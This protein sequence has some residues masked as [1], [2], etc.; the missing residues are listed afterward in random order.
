MLHGGIVYSLGVAAVAA[1]LVIEHRLV[2]GNL[3]EIQKAFFDCNY[4]SLGF[5]AATV[6]DAFVR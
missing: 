2:R 6:L 5:F 4:V 3:S 1:V